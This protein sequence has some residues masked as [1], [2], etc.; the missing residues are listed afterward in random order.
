[1]YMNPNNPRF[2][3][4]RNVDQNQP[5]NLPLSQ[6]FS[7]R[8]Q[9]DAYA[10]YPDRMNNSYSIYQF[11]HRSPKDKLFVYIKGITNEN[12]NFIFSFLNQICE[13]AC[14]H[15]C[16]GGDLIFQLKDPIDESII[17]NI[18]SQKAIHLDSKC[19]NV[20][21]KYLTEKEKNEMCNQVGNQPQSF[22]Q[23]QPNQN[24]GN[25][26]WINKGQ[27]INMA[28]LRFQVGP[29]KSI[30]RHFIDILLGID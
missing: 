14:Q 10:N 4:N 23:R 16:N 26:S 28:Y 7:N 9:Q 15:Q 29:K 12:Y 20:E 21:F 22:Y 18:N 30:F 25:D 19:Q 17:S 11:G 5:M 3:N 1:M 6:A 24:L 8:N 13:I 2:S 27:R